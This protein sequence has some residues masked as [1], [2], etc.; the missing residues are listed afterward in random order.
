MIKNP[1]RATVFKTLDHY[2][3]QAIVTQ[4][5]NGDVVALFNEE[6]AQAHRDNGY[7]TLIRSFDGGRTWDPTTRVVVLPA[8][9]QTGNWDCA[10][11][12]LQDGT[13]LVTLCQAAYFRRGIDSEAPQY[14]NSQYTLL[15]SWIGTF[16]LRSTD[17]GY[18]WSAPIPMNTMPMKF[19]STRV[20]AMQQ[21]DGSILFPLYGR[22][23]E[24]GYGL[25]EMGGEAMRA[26]MLRSDDNGF[27]WEYFSTIAYDPARIVGYA[28]P[29]PLRLPDGRLI[30]MLRVHSRPTQRPDNIYMVLSDDDGH[31]WSTP[32]RL[33]DLWGYPAQLINLKDGRVLMTFG[34]RR[35]E[36]G[37]KGVISDDGINWDGTKQF[38][39][40]EG[41]Q[42]PRN[43]PT[44]WHTGYPCSTQLTDESIVTVYHL[45]STDETP[46][47][48][49][50]SVRWELS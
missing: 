41:G 5:A 21:P 14:D 12:Q 43:E 9:D 48:Y 26:Y 32:R 49:I 42:G 46:V 20:A 50:E 30:V 2:A 17:N 4:L 22:L 11:T 28:E 39:I 7:T 33:K 18:T 23:D 47:Q 13:L 38:S 29:A 1:Q 34:Y 25:R 19:G 3:N 8:T 27:N 6:R 44:W 24:F 45:F 36:F 40:H 35:G 10:L 37:V 16:T 15:R 31:T